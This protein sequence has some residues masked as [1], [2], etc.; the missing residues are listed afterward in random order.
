MCAP[1][2]AGRWLGYTGGKVEI[3]G[4]PARRELAGLVRAKIEGYASTEVLG[5]G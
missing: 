5:A 4:V 1:S 3:R 2:D